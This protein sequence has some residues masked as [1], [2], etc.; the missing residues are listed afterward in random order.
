MT[1]GEHDHTRPRLS[2]WN[3]FADEYTLDADL[4]ELD[5]GV[6]D[7]RQRY[8]PGE[9]AREI[10]LLAKVLALLVTY[11]HQGEPCLYSHYGV[12]DLP[13]VSECRSLLGH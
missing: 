8:S 9:I 7:R 2:H 10:R 3:R 5:Q 4:A 6:F 1:S 13:A 11:R 12:A